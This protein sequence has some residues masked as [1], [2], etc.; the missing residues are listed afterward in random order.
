MAE[1]TKGKW[2]VDEDNEYL[3]AIMVG[4]CFCY[5]ADCDSTNY[6]GQ[7]DKPASDEA[8]ARRIVACLNALE[9]IPTEALET[10]I[11]KE[12]IDSYK[13]L[14]RMGIEWAGKHGS[15]LPNPLPLEETDG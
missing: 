4:D 15:R 2:V 11:T 5:I 9:G 13:T 8:N 3:V 14:E 6:S 1:H 7:F 10:G 12:L